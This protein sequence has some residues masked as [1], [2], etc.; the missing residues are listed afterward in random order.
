[1]MPLVS[2][3]DTDSGDAYVQVNVSES[4][5]ITEIDNTATALNFSGA[6]IS[7]GLVRTGNHAVTVSTSSATGWSLAMHAD[8]AT[9]NLRTSTG[10]NVYGGASG[11]TG[12]GGTATDANLTAALNYATLGTGAT[13]APSTTPPAAGAWGFRMAGW[14]ADNYVSVPTSDI[15]IAAA[16]AA[17]TQAVTVTFGAQA[18]T[19]T[20]AGYYGAWI[21]YTATTQ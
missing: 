19:T 20:P 2:Y 18:G 15:I 17:G 7:N 4:I 12:V 14:T 21:T 9:L 10:P 8:T 3:A 16:D 13:F 11:F 5:T 1:L 6:D